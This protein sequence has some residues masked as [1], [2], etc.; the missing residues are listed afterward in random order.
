MHKEFWWEELLIWLVALKTEMKMD[1]KEM[2]CKSGGLMAWGCAQ[3]Q[4]LILGML[5]F[6]GL[7]PHSYVSWQHLIV[8]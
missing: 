7:L 6:W 4:A 5:N 3:W 1:L 8:L 2:V